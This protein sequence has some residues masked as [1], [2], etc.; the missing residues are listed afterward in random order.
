MSTPAAT[1][2]QPRPW[3]RYATASTIGL[4][5]IVGV[6]GV[7]MFFHVAPGPLKAAHEWLSLL[8]VVAAVVHVVRN[9]KA[10]TKLLRAPSTWI[11]IGGAVLASALFFLAPGD[12][13]SN[14]MRALAQSAQRAPI[15]A[16]APVLGV[17]S[18][19]LLA[20]LRQNGIQA[21]DARLSAD[22]IAAKQGLEP[23]RVLSAMLTKAPRDA[24]AKGPRRSGKA[25]S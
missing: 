19:E 22:E 1:A 9:G 23:Q 21:D 14:P 4:F 20:R 18:D 25:G 2:A 24:Q 6:T 3:A 8:F 16:L 11:V 5:L 13:G 10:F 12:G 17:S 15:S 7:L